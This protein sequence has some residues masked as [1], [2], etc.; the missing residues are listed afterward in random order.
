MSYVRVAIKGTITGGEVWS[1]N[2]V[3]D[4]NGELETTVDQT[5]L[6]AAALAIANIVPGSNLRLMMGPDVLIVGSRLEVRA[7]ATNN[8]I[9]VSN[10]GSTAPIGGTGSSRLPPQ[11]SLVCSLRTNTPGGSGRGRIYLPIIGATIGANLRLNA[12]QFAAAAG[13][14]KT[15]L[16]AMQ[17]ALATQFTPITFNL[18]VRSVKT[19]TTPHVVRLQVGDVLDTQ[20]RRRDALPETYS[21]VTYP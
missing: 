8:I 20:R 6:D 10:A 2:P 15:Y 14:F 9:A 17:S 18:A 3:F 1:I 5:K 16:A 12:T 21:S 4:P 11:T 7:D 13:E 19:N